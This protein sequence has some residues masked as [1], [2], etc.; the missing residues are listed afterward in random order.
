MADTVTPAG[1]GATGHLL[2]PRV[3]YDPELY[4]REQDELFGSVWTFAGLTTDLAKPGSYR[5]VQAG[6][7]PLVVLRDHDGN[8][9]AHHNVCRHRGTAVLP[10]DSGRVGKVIRCPYHHWTY[11]LDGCLL[12]V[13]QRNEVDPKLDRSK[14][15]LHPASV[16]VWRGVVFVHPDPDPQPLTDWLGELP[17][18]IAP[19]DPGDLVQLGVQE[20][21]VKANWKVFIENSLDNYHLGYVHA[22]N[23]KSYDHKRQEGH[24][25]GRH[26]AFHEPPLE[27]G[28]MP[29]E[30][31]GL[32]PILDE[33]R[34]FGSGYG[35]VFP[36]LFIL[37]GATYWTTAEVN[38]VGPERTKLVFRVMVAPGQ[39]LGALGNAAH[40]AINRLLGRVRTTAQ[41]VR[42]SLRAG[43]LDGDA[44]K[45]AFRNGRKYDLL[46][47]DMFC[48]EAVQRGV[49]SP[50]FEVG[51][52]AY[53]YEK[54]IPAFHRN[55]L[56]YIS[57]GEKDV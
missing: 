36:R 17:G 55:Y 9:R 49:R 1:T 21:D 35:Y 52:L 37:S 39:G 22:E 32:R 46:E 24:D 25:C 40:G 45:A 38:P 16:A 43:E 56:D 33:P 3:F 15:G 29:P 28:K 53:R 8:L 13:S 10:G 41:S 2:P 23:L 19:V 11:G 27:P 4:E 54:A 47:E 6:R 50:R 18:L 12:G 48:C 51:P 26:W 42:S 14:L 30:E 57:L 34:W 5:S 31:F 44:L 7:H 20:Y